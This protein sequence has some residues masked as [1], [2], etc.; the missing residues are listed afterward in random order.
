L[1]RQF[2]LLGLFLLV[3][4]GVWYLYTP[5]LLPIFVA[6]LLAL[7]TSNLNK[8]LERFVK[9]KTLR[10]LIM[11]LGLG[12]LFFAPIVYA[13]N[14]S[15][16][17]INNFDSTVVDKIIGLKN[18]VDIPDYLGFVKEYIKGLDPQEITKKIVTFGSTTFK[19]SAGFFKDMFLI[20]IFYFFVNLYSKELTKFLKDIL[21]FD[22]NSP[23]F[24]E[25]S[26]VMSVVFYSTLLTALL[27]G[28]LFAIIVMFFGYDGLLFGILYGFASLIPVIGGLVMWLPVSLYE[29]ASGNIS[30]AIIIAI[31]SIVVI[32]IIADT[33]IKPMIIK[34]VRENITKDATK[35]NE[36]VIFFSI[37]AGLTT[38]GFWGMVI[39]P[40]ITTFFISLAKIY[41]VLLDEEKSND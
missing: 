27:E 8:Y 10:A 38:Y 9:F 37:I 28:A 21:P 30:S 19:K 22:K 31:Y 39:G 12:L 3:L 11:T 14:A 36:I 32:S 26:G 18:S 5:F 16:H 17:I 24:Q 20:L 33:F 35:I 2:F 25:I 23:F 29:Y 15:T 7:A 34:Y 4:Y 6:S 13:T 1:T 41:Q 40:A